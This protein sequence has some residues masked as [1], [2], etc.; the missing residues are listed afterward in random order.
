MDQKLKMNL[1]PFLDQ[2]LKMDQNPRMDHN[3]KMDQTQKWIKPKNALIKM[4]QNPKIIR[5]KFKNSYL[6]F[7][8]SYTWNSQQ[9][10][11]KCL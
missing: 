9:C 6:Y 7:G 3:P 1:N 5:L 8:F 10:L 2:N 4:V 11:K